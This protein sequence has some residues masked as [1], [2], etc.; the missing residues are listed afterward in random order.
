MSEANLIPGTVALIPAAGGGIRLGQGPKAFLEIGKKSL[1]KHVVDLMS[2]RVERIL[3]AVPEDH[4]ALARAQFEGRAEVHPGGATRLSTIAGLLAQCSESLVV[5]HDAARPFTSVEV[6]S[7]VIEE[8]AVHG[9][10]AAC[11]TMTVPTAIIENGFAKSSVPPSRGRFFETPHAYQRSILEKTFRY[12]RENAVADEPL[13]DLVMSLGTPIR[14]VADT[15][16]NF[17]I[18]TPLDWEIAVKVVGPMLGMG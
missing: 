14:V 1:V 10:A 3:V 15:E 5:I 11:R 8:A 7:R 4:V 18:T 13:C 9:A 12:V 16:W 17:K 2:Q 6:L